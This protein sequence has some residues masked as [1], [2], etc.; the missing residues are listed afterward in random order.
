MDRA[1]GVYA[2]V[3]DESKLSLQYN[4]SSIPYLQR[5]RRKYNNYLPA[6]QVRMGPV[7]GENR[8]P[9]QAYVKPQLQNAVFNL[10]V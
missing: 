10:N 8:T 5:N 7:K 1:R 4:S 9:Q 2:S 3:G 6:D